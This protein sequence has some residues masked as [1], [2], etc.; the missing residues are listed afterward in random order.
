[1]REDC[2]QVMQS[3]RSAYSTSGRSSVTCRRGLGDRA[4]AAGVCLRSRFINSDYIKIGRT[5]DR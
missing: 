3:R 4:Y 5:A 2:P 1:M